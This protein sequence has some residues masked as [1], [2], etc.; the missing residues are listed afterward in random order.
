VL[1]Q[2]RADKHTCRVEWG[3]G[4]TSQ[5]KPSRGVC[6]AE[7]A[8][9]RPG[10]YQPKLS[11]TDDDGGTT[12][13]ET[14]KYV[15]VYDPRKPFLAGAG[16][17]D[18]GSGPAT[19]GIVAGRPGRGGG[20]ELNLRVRFD[21][22]AFSATAFTKV[23]GGGEIR[24]EGKGALGGVQGYGYQL[25]LVDTSRQRGGPDRFWIKITDKRGGLVY[26]SRTG[27][28][29]TALRSGDILNRL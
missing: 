12:V 13:A 1:D 2:G 25:G 14:A 24:Y 22:R 7:H 6:K 9:A 5:T 8:Y 10:V 19:F 29:G 26:D 23:T 15:A 18:S 4:T 11:V 16:T 28:R 21:T 27:G 17:I 3:D 20:G